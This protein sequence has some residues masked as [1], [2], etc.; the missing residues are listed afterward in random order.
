M[1][2]GK[3]E[4]APTGGHT[5]VSNLSKEATQVQPVKTSVSKAPSEGVNPKTPKPRDN[6]S[7]AVKGFKLMETTEAALAELYTAPDTSDL[8]DIG[9]ASFGPPPPAT[10]T[11]HGPDDRIQITSTSIYPWRVH[12]S[13]LITAA[14]GSRWIGTGWFIGPHTLMTAG[15]VVYIKNSGVP[16]RD[17]WVRN[18][19]V[20]PGRNGSTLPYGTVRSSNFRSVTGW[21]NSGDQNFDYGAIII[22]TNLGNTT[23]WFGFGVYSDADLLAS[24]GN[25][26]GYPGDKPTG[27]QW[28]DARRIASV[29][30]R[31]VY[32]D[33]DTFGGQSGS[34]VY[35]IIDGGRYGV[36]IHAY[37][38][39]TTNSGT[40]IVRP[41]YDNMV[42]WR[43]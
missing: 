24:V 36:A 41:V 30:A 34:A 42:A 18:I 29:N 4:S 27:T 5:P 7:E 32:Y 10:E 31:K 16:G 26:S 33:I 3:K 22:P 23:G 9:E 21:T 1:P 38:G 35:R 17:G 13:L 15:H 19:D 11:V 25:I 20:M 43:A 12:A 39:A 2:T 6:G 8:R 37:G 40:R 14:D 28:Y